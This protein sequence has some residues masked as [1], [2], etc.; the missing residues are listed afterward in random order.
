VIFA[1]QPT[2]CF[3]DSLDPA[4][5]HFCEEELCAVIEQPANTWSNLAYIFVGI[6]VARLAIKEGHKHLS[7]I[8]VVAAV[9]G[10]GSF[11]F[12]MSSTHLGEIVDLGA[13]FF[14]SAYVLVINFRRY[15][16]REYG[17]WSKKELMAYLA[18]ALSGC[19]VTY[20]FKGWVGTV[21][22]AVQAT[23]AGSLEVRTLR[24]RQENV[25]Y[26][27]MLGLLFAFGLAWTLWWFDQ[28]GIGC[29]P[30]NHLIQGHAGWHLSNAFVFYFLYRFYAQLPWTLGSKDEL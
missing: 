12:H 8:G 2:T 15:V 9:I 3:W 18:L 23:I 29:N 26:K 4:V 19:L 27:P 7:F 6:L 1:Q 17:P 10:V 11:F 16:H 20:L 25:S 30:T 21:Y 5:V 24:F 22:F 14:F 13:M 28:L